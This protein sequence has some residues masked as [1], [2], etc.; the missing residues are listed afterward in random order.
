MTGFYD[1]N[2]FNMDGPAHRE[3]LALFHPAAV[4]RDMLGMTIVTLIYVI[5]GMMGQIVFW[6]GVLMLAALFCYIGFTVWHDNKSND[7]VAEL[8]RAD[9]R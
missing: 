5:L 3:A 1:L 7:E 2:L 6:H 9:E 8:H 4:K